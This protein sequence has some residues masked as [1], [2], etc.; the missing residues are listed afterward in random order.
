[1]TTP[2][3]KPGPGRR[4]LAGKPCA[5]QALPA[6]IP[7]AQGTKPCNSVTENPMAR[8][9]IQLG[10][11]PIDEPC[12]QVGTPD[13][14][15][16]ARLECAVFKDQILRTYPLPIAAAGRAGLRFTANPHDFGTYYELAVEFDPECPAAVDWAFLIDAGMPERWDAESLAVLCDAGY[17]LAFQQVQALDRTRRE[18]AAVVVT[19]QHNLDPQI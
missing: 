6:C 14:A 9:Q 15:S 12:A 7:R 2:G 19:W 13:Y 5:P 18:P 4:V 11:V 1:M 16:R 17:R 3:A 10:V 8:E